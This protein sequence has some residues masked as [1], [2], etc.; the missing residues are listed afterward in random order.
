MALGI[1]TAQLTKM[2]SQVEELLPDTCVIQSSANSTDSMGGV[3]QT[4]TAVSGGTVSCRVDPLGNRTAQLELYAQREATKILQQL[5][6]PYDAPLSTDYRVV[7]GGNTYEI[8][9]LD[10]VHS[11]NVS[12]RAIISEVE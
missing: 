7:T 8:I 3:T 9:Q 11:W 10:V 2:R 1:S 4:Y 6:V 5:T 12:K